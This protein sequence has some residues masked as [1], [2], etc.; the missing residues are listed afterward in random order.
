M[1]THKLKKFIFIQ[2]LNEKIKKNIKKLSNVRII[3]NNINN[4]SLGQILTI[5]RF[6]K[7]N[8]IP[9]Y[10]MDDYKTALTI[11][12]DGVFISSG[13][14]RVN[15]KKFL[16]KKFHIIGSAHN[17]LEYYFKRRQGC[18]IISLSPIFFNP[19]FSKEK[20]LKPIKFNLI[21]IN[22]SETICAL[23]GVNFSNIGKISHSNKIKSIAYH[24]AIKNPPTNLIVDGL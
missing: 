6:C 15:L 2:D 14:K 10:I 11:N 7:A 16:N 13:N 9:F 20:A 4:T 21:S 24:R 3:Y 19:K 23:G 18:K 22:W 5:K 17:Q 1:T 8:S 12:A